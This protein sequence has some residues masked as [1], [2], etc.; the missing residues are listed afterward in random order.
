ML[1]PRFA[2]TLGPRPEAEQPRELRAPRCHLEDRFGPADGCVLCEA[3]PPAEKW[4]LASFHDEQHNLQVRLVPKSVLAHC[5]PEPLV[6]K[7][8]GGTARTRRIDRDA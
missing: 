3:P 4:P 2:L 7:F 6:G 8:P 1:L 5:P